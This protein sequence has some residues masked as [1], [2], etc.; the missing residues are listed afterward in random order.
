[1][2]ENPTAHEATENKFCNVQVGRKEKKN[3]GGGEQR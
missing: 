3:S 2:G 1:M